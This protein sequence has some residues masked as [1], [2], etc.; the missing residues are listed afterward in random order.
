PHGGGRWLRRLQFGQARPMALP[1]ERGGAHGGVLA[2]QGFKAAARTAAQRA[3][4]VAGS[5][6]LQQLG[7]LLEVHALP[8]TRSAPCSRAVVPGRAGSRSSRCPAATPVA[9]PVRC[10]SGRANTPG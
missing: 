7:V 10:G 6:L 4:R 3:E 1:Q 8:L 9:G 5:E 2:R